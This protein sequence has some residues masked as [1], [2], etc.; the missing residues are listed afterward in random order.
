MKRKRISVL[1][2][3]L[4]LSVL[5]SLASCASAADS[6]ETGA[7]G[8]DTAVNTIMTA[9]T[10]QAFSDEAVP[11]EDIRTILQAG[12]AAESA[13]NQQ[14]W[15]FV[16]VTDKDVMNE[17]ASSGGGPGGGSMPAFPQDGSMPSGFPGGDMPA[18]PQG[19]GKPSGF[20]GGDMPA[21]PQGGGKPSGSQ[22]GEAPSAPQDGT[23]PAAPPSGDMPA[24]PQN[25]SMPSAPEGSTPSMAGGGAKAALGDSPLAILVYMDESTSS[26]NPAF[27]CGLAVQN[28]YIAAASLGYG[29]KII[30]SPTR[31]LNGADHD[32]ICGKLGV[33]PSLTAV[34]VLLVGKPDQSVDGVSGASVRSGLDEKTVLVG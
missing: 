24:P 4:C 14:P 17:L 2:L 3:I 32:Q 28:M 34:A 25:G 6:A 29:V 20:P 23:A 1:S 15:F 22:G 13:I 9:G 18:P 5:F 16:A 10:T 11:E 12:L 8:A 21:L 33:D 19:G 31:S 27:D 30:S 7:D 26:P